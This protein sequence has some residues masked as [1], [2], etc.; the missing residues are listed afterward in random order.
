[1]EVKE[2]YVEYG[3]STAESVTVL[4]TE[5]IEAI[6]ELTDASL[7]KRC[8]ALLAKPKKKYRTSEFI[9]SLVVKGGEE[10]P[11][12]INSIDTL[13]DTKYK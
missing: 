7:L 6:R 3:L 8:L 13:I 10:V 1:M 9:D 5:L 11:A 2:P 12:D 4:K